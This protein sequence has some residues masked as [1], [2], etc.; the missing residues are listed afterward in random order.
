ME[1]KESNL[2]APR[3]KVIADYP[4]NHDFVLHQIIVL[5][6]WKSCDS[7]WAHY[8]EDCQGERSWLEDFFKKYPHLF[9]PLEWWQDRE[10]IPEYVKFIAN[11]SKVVKLLKLYN[12]DMADVEDDG[13]VIDCLD[14]ELFLPATHEE[15]LSYQKQKQ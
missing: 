1:A 9:E 10:D 14:M 3:Y 7:Y 15:Y 8:V 5:V 4:G 13:K 2:M 11:K 12:R 6:P